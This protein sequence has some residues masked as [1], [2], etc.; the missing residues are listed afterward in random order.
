[1]NRS[2]IS[3]LAGIVLVI[4]V[5]FYQPFRNLAGSII[6]L[7]LTATKA[8]FRF[9]VQ[10]PFLAR[11]SEDNQTLRNT[12]LEQHLELVRLRE[13]L[14]HLEHLEALNE[15]TEELSGISAQVIG[16]SPIPTQ[17]TILIDRGRQDGVVVASIVVNVG[18]V[19]GRVIEVYPKTSLVLLLTDPD[20]RVSSLVERTREMAL[21][22]GMSHAECR[23]IHLDSDADIEIG[24]RILTAGLGGPFPKGLTL[25]SIT[26]I[27]RDEDTNRAVAWV[28]PEADMGHLEEVM[29]L[30]PTEF[31]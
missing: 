6:L 13:E 21:L 24:D 25:G 11:L 30:W 10:I 3:L 12:V 29:I 27:K 28:R 31:Q 2:R 23:L 18:G 19:L 26:R 1:M 14:R 16:R 7:P 22:I 15:Q 20:S 8:V 4:S 17:H 5:L 9:V